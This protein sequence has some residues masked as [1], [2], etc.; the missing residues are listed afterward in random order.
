MTL[1]TFLLIL[2]ILLVLGG[3]NYL[4]GAYAGPGNILGLVLVVLLVV[5]IVRGGI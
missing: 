2:V 5:V 1:T 4:G 3:S